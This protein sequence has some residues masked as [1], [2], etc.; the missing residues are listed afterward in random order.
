MDASALRR[1]GAVCSG[2]LAGHTGADWS[3]PVPDLDWT[4][5]E[6]VAHLGDTSLWYATDLAA[7]PPELSTAEV[8]V[9]PDSA[10][11]DLV[12]TVSA[13]VALL[14]AV[15]E[16]SPADARGWHPWGEPDPAG[17]AAMACD[18][19]LVHTR[20][21]ALGLGVEFTPPAE[22]AEATLRRLFPETPDGGDPWPELLWCNGRLELPGRPRRSGWRWHCSPLAEWNG[23]A[24]TR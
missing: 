24:A 15:V 7:G 17:F 9:R 4:V 14:A 19:L 8:K 12:R 10:P 3:A 1:V 22:L 20:D 2:F 21:A 6:V 5:R 23:P 13:H 16:A 11:E 18:E